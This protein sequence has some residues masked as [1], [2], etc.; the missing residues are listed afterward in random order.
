MA[1][2][3]TPREWLDWYEARRGEEVAPLDDEQV[4]FCEE[5][6]FIGFIVHDD[7]FEIHQMA[8]DS[9]DWWK[10]QVVRLMKELGL[11][12]LRFFTRRNPNAIMR[13]HGGRIRGYYM[14]MDVSE[15]EDKI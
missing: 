10:P 15:L 2:P 8:S 5:H 7:V 11:G 13:K 9:A 6:G 3:K 14:E 1:K 4:L 12:K